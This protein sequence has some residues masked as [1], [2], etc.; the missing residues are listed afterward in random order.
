MESGLLLSL[1]FPIDEALG[2]WVLIPVF[3]SGAFTH[4]YLKTVWSQMN[5]V[6]SLSSGGQKPDNKVLA[7]QQALRSFWGKIPLVCPILLQPQAGTPGLSSWIALISVLSS[8]VSLCLALVISDLGP[9][10]LQYRLLLMTPGA[11]L[12]PDKAIV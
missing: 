7:G 9:I 12:L 5:R 4:K 3:I 6:P 8:A 2:T 1:H 11:T 10:L